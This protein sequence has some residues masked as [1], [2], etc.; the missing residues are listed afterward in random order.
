MMMNTSRFR[1][2]GRLWIVVAATAALFGL[3]LCGSGSPAAAQSASTD[4]ST[5]S[6]SPPVD[7]NSPELTHRLRL[8]LV[9]NPSAS[10]P[11]PFGV[12][13]YSSPTDSSAALPLAEQAHVSWI[14]WPIS[15]SSI[16]PSNTT[17]E[18]YHFDWLD[19]QITAAR[20]RGLHLVLTLQ[21]NPSW[22]ATYP[23]GPIDKVNIKEFADVMGALAER[24]DGDGWHDA[25]GS[26]VVDYWEFYN[27][28]DNG[29]IAAG[30]DGQGYWG[31]NG[32]KYAQMLC[33]VYPAM[34]AASSRA[35]VA[36]GG[37]G[38]DYF[39]EEGGPFVRRFLDDVLKAGGGRCLDVMTFH[40]YPGYEPNW[41]PYGV[42]L[43]GKAN[44]L[45]SLLESY[46]IR[47]LPM[48]VTE[49]GHHSNYYAKWPST[50]EIQAGWVVKL[51]AQSLAADLRV[52]IW[53]TWSDYEIYGASWGENGLLNRNL[54][55]KQA[56][57]AYQ[58]AATQLGQAVFQRI[59]SAGELGCDNVQAYL[60]DRGTPFYVLW[61]TGEASESV[62]LPGRSARVVDYAGN[63]VASAADGADGQTDGKVRITVNSSPVYV[64]VT[65]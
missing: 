37:I 55:P 13:V 35:Q 64:E 57:Y 28:P 34:K 49:T 51:F 30:E 43:S 60:F 65:P 52:M 48:I 50:P 39:E 59:L 6:D 2:R 62:S 27:E 54:Q 3:I 61:S 11:T 45:Q 21:G 53:W 9:L 38:Y 25:P 31:H 56:Y 18:N 1:D 16:E 32:V 40:Y 36:L 20:Q 7:L 63:T 12:Q 22:A 23:G 33:A 5:P 17:P 47:G 58:T 15:W 19:T 14:R 10:I 29:S 4:P 26:P 44:F 46:G 24:Y 41:A 8:P 42:G